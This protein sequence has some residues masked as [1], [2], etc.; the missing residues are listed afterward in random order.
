[1]PRGPIGHTPRLVEVTDNVTPVPATDK[2]VDQGRVLLIDD[3]PVVLETVGEL[4]ESWGH[5]VTTAERADQGLAALESAS[6]EVVVADVSM[7]GM[8]G[9]E[10]LAV[11]RNRGLETPVIMLS[12]DSDSRTVL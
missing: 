2:H 1:M 7:P 8:N 10:L 12:A 9:L 4:I 11:M 6:F 5:Q 3:S